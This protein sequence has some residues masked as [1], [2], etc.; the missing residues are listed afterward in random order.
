MHRLTFAAMYRLGITPWDGHPLPAWLREQIEQ[1][2]GLLPGRALDVGCG[3]GDTSIY[4]AQHGWQVTGIDF[5]T[6]ALDEARSKTSAAGVTVRYQRADVT[7]LAAYGVG[8]GFDLIADNGCLHGLNDNQ[9]DAYVREIGAAAAPGARLLIMA[10]AARARRGPRGIDR[11]ELETRFAHRWELIGSGEDA[12]ASTLA[13]D[14]LY[15]YDL[16]RRL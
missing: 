13:D 10:F 8:G 3:T 12:D 11:A 16:R 5:V 4:L 9:R 2:G 15:F 1:P 7:R 6:R 14:P